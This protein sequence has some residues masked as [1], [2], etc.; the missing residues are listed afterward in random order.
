MISFN[1][2]NL[3]TGDIF[4]PANWFLI[5]VALAWII[6]AVIQDFKHREVENWWSFSLMI[7]ALV[8]RAFLSIENNNYWYFLWGVIG[9][10][11][12]FGIMNAL[13]Y[14][15]IFAG[16][17][18]KLLMAL[19]AIIPL[20]LSWENNL[21]M[22]A[23]FL[24]LM[25][26]SGAI[27]GLLYSII[28]ALVRFKEFKREFSKQFKKYRAVIYAIYGAGIILLAAM[29]ILNIYLG[30]LLI[31]IILLMIF[32]FIY[33]RVVEEVNMKKFVNVG[34]LTIGDWLG[35]PIKVRGRI[36]KP[37]WEGLSEEELGFIQKNYKKK[38]LVKY[39][40]PFTPAFLLGFL[41]LIWILYGGILFF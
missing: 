13:Y 4:T 11:I 39:G 10:A 26:L 38:V 41:L 36:I 24:T 17:D 25:I 7:F 1:L 34:E 12:G 23:A 28:L 16:G 6:I 5:A 30:I 37:Y 19:G 9:L 32:L 40:I 20:S 29:I 35:T 15:R 3:N 18:A 14:G 2:F 21:V 22:F 8:F 31:L 33:A 27:Y